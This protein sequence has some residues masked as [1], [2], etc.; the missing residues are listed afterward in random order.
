MLALSVGNASAAIASTGNV[1][2]HVHEP[3]STSL[4]HASLTICGVQQKND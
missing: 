3:T 2:L 4:P 1:C